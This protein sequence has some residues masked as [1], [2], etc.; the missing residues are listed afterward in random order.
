MSSNNGKLRQFGGFTLDPEKLVLWFEDRPVNL[1]LK[2]VELLSALTANAGEVVT[3]AE[4][5]DRIWKDSFVEESNLSRHVYILRKTFRE[6]GV[7]DLIETVPRRGYRFVGSVLEPDVK[8]VI[9]ERRVVSQT[10]IEDISDDVNTFPRGQSHSIYPIRST[11]APVAVATLAFLL[12]GGI[13]FA[14]WKGQIPLTSASVTGITSL[15]VLPFTP[16]NDSPE[17]K[18]QGIGLTD[19]LITRLSNLKSISV[20]SITSVADLDPRDPIASGKL[21]NVDAVVVGTIYRSGDKTRVSA[22]ILKVSDGNALWTGEFERLSANDMRIQNDLALQLTN[23]LAPKLDAVEKK[24][25]AKSYTEDPEAFRLYQE[26]RSEW[27]KRS[28]R[29]ATDA[30]RFF[31]EAI[32]KDPEFALAYAGLAEVMSTMNADEAEVI[33]H[34]AI[35]LDPDLAEAHSALGFIQTFVHRNWAEAEKELTRSIDLNPNYAQAH[36]WYGELLAILGRN[37]DA[38]V[39]IN[40][41]LEIDPLSHNYLAALGQI[42]YFN[43]EYKEAEFYCRRAL[44]QEP[45][46]TFAHEYLS[47]IYVQT[48]EFEKAV[49]ARFSAER[50]NGRFSVDSAEHMNRYEADIEKKR[51][52]ALQQGLKAFLQGQLIGSN[53]IL[54]SYYDARRY[55]A[56]GDKESALRSLEKA[57]QSKAFHTAFM[58]VDPVFDAIRNDPRYDLVLRRINLHDMNN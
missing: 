32:A 50:I 9:V 37:A 11:V 2:E 4:L 7:C 40:R 44:D 52:E 23:A 56:L 12:I 8:P 31:R 33:V 35:E 55:A 18:Q 19:T 26:A 21:L 51:S 43:R 45:E 53:E 27:N 57:V 39:E 34:R 24:A 15:A 14:A 22:R 29:G 49:D 36:H 58:K 10:T 38:K 13:V 16:L 48:G 54:V 30:V 17:A 5:L 1:A 25:I 6:F 28:T 41:A 20:R 46:F 42:Y 47:D 3:K